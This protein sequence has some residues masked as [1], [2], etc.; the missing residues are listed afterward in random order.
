[1]DQMEL[2]LEKV[3]KNQDMKKD[4][5]ST[6]THFN[7]DTIHEIQISAKDR[8]QDTGKRSVTTRYIKAFYM[9][10]FNRHQ[11]WFK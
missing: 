10:N 9:L 7:Q 4:T 11:T 6:G 2:V 5:L 8:M 1:V 3:T